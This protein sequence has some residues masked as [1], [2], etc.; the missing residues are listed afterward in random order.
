MS[1]DGDNGDI[2]N[3]ICAS[4]M[5]SIKPT[6]VLIDVDALARWE[7][8]KRQKDWSLRYAKKTCE[9]RLHHLSKSSVL[10]EEV[11]LPAQLESC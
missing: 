1:K 10:Q 9:Q 2:Y 11:N 5:R 3:M 6:E 7:A 4:D 8:L